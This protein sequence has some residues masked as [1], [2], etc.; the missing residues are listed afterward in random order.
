[1]SINIQVKNTDSG[2]TLSNKTS[3]PVSTRMSGFVSFNLPLGG[4][5][6]MNGV[7]QSIQIMFSAAGVDNAVIIESA[8]FTV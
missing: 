7:V 2:R 6:N 5:E 4:L 1:M 8:T 3:L